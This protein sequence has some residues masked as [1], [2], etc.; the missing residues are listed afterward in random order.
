MMIKDVISFV[1]QFNKYWDN[2][3]LR[4]EYKAKKGCYPEDDESEPIDVT[5]GMIREFLKKQ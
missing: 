3:I 5:D 4:E 2:P 1:K